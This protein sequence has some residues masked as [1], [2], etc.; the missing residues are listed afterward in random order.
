MAKRCHHLLGIIK[1]V[2]Q[3]LNILVLNALPSDSPD[4]SA[5][6]SASL[7][8]LSTTKSRHIVGSVLEFYRRNI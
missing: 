7:N 2:I 5:L 6:V 8:L 3:F 1:Y 4:G